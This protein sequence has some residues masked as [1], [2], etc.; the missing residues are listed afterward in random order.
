[1]ENS[2]MMN[3]YELKEILNNGV[4]TI[5]FTKTDGTERT[6]KCTLLPEYMPANI[7]QSQ[8]LL[9]EETQRVEN[10]NTVSVWDIENNGWRS[11]RIDSVKSIEK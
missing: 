5:V 3:K 2:Q 8:K 4:A 10:P 6:M 9:T 1:M 11:F 7:H